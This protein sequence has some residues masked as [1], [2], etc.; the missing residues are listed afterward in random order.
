[1]LQKIFNAMKRLFTAIQ[2]VQTIVFISFI[3]SS[4]LKA[5]V[6]GVCGANL[7]PNHDF[8]QNNTTLCNS[9]I[10]GIGQIWIDTSIVTSW[11]GTSFK[12]G[13][14]RGITPDYYNSNCDGA[15]SSSDC[16]NGAGS[17]GVYTSTSAGPASTS[18]VREYI[19]CQLNA[20]LTAGRSYYI[21]MKVRSGASNSWAR[22]DGFG[23]WFRQATAPI[24][25]A[26]QNGIPF[27]AATPQFENQS[28]SI[29]GDSC[30]VI[31]GYF[32]ATGGENWLVLGN[33]KTDAQ[34]VV[35]YN[36][37]SPAYVIV[38]DVFVQEVCP[39]ATPAIVRINADNLSLSC[40][41]RVT[42]NAEVI[43]GS[44]GV[45][46]YSWISP[47]SLAGSTSPGP[48]TQTL[49]QNT[50]YKI[51]YTV[52]GPCGSI[53]DTT[54]L[55]VD[56][57]SGVQINQSSLVNETCLGICDGSIRVNVSGGTP[58]YT[59]AWYNASDNLLGANPITSLC[60]GDYTYRVTTT[61][62][63]QKRDTILS[64]GFENGSPGWTLN[65]NPTGGASSATPNVW[66]V[67]NETF[68]P[69]VASCIPTNDYT[70]NLRCGG[71]CSP[72]S[73]GNQLGS[74][75]TSVMAETPVINAAAYSNLTLSFD[76]LAEADAEAQGSVYYYNGS[77]WVLISSLTSPTCW[78]PYNGWGTYSVSL[79]AALNNN[80][81]IKIGFLWKNTNY[82]VMPDWGMA[83]DNVIISGAKPVSITCAQLDTFR[84]S[85][86]NCQGCN[87]SVSPSVTNETCAGENDGALRFTISGSGL[88]DLFVNNV[89]SL[90][91]I[92]AGTHN[93]TSLSDGTYS[94]KVV[95]LSTQN[96]DTL[97]SVA[98]T[99][100]ST[101]IIS[102]QSTVDN[103]SCSNPNGSIQISSNASSYKLYT[104]PGDNLISSN[105]TGNFAGLAA[106][107]YY[108]S[109][110][111]NSCSITTSTIAVNGTVNY[112]PALNYSGTQY[113]CEGDT[114]ALSVTSA[115]SNACQW[116][117]NVA[118]GLN[119]VV[120]AGAYF[121]NC[122]SASG[123]SGRSD[124]VFVE[125]TNRPTA[126]FTYTQIDNYT[127][128]FYNN[129]TQATNYQW[130]LLGSSTTEN[131]ASYDFLFEGIYPV[132]LIASNACGVDTAVVDVVVSKLT[133]IAEIQ[134]NKPVIFPNPAFDLV[135]IV[136]PK[137]LSKTP[138]VI[139]YGIDGKRHAV[140]SMQTDAYS[141]QLHVEQ[142]VPGVYQLEL[143]LSDEILH[144][145]II[146]Q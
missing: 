73:S 36:V 72:F 26:D 77:A 74:F 70:L 5:Q 127:V 55:S 129:S 44:Y 18:N 136:F 61:E 15:N 60:S 84:I 35:D 109:V 63:I 27:I 32:C 142:L 102:S 112:R 40:G 56:V 54:V 28:G 124:T 13:Q 133:G 64:V 113:L 86:I 14:G 141:I 62:T 131:N 66:E 69:N 138:Q 47:P 132:Q 38:D 23:A 89:L 30:R 123:C 11:Y 139:V 33:F 88:F 135:N 78:G 99:S 1:M 92:S 76:Y 4:Q 57:N 108:V 68:G 79:P 116:S 93:L 105:A 107:N 2:L 71:A 12:N 3:S 10:A 118:G 25:I 130:L 48:F 85:G 125:V 146:I 75:T 95:N 8:E 120:S 97:F 58:P 100:G 114:L 22:T 140:E 21:Q 128:D 49:S 134:S 87:F 16:M 31:S 94:I 51:R 126:A 82:I 34:L 45:V 24:N 20:P 106:G 6:P 9:S 115:G 121:V 37:G 80:P 110:T 46:S 137:K 81:A 103:T 91:N 7:V 111:S 104:T 145:T 90:D 122:E 42:V 59:G 117:N 17:L 43:T 50:N 29:I 143:N 144:K 53:T 39:G 52:N 98:I 119:E 65:T 101:I 19:Q 96:C 67:T 83:I 41:E